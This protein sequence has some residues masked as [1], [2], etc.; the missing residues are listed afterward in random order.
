MHQEY[1][2]TKMLVGAQGGTKAMNSA[3]TF[4]RRW[5]WRPLQV[6]FAVVAIA[7]LAACQHLPLYNKEKDELAK[8]AQK[9]Y[10]DTKVTE[11]LNV[12]EKN[13][14]KLLKAEIDALNESASLRLDI[15]L[16]CMADD[17]PVADG[18]TL[19]AA[20]YVR[21]E[22]EETDLG[23]PEPG[24]VL[25]MLDY[26]IEVA[27]ASVQVATVKGRIRSGSDGSKAIKAL[28]SCGSRIHNYA[29]RGSW[30]RPR[31]CFSQLK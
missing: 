11:A 16:L 12:Q 14:E 21:A 8:S 27:E 22:K 18:S 20:W 2:G 31:Q 23:F 25:A 1:N 19:L 29:A 15:A 24:Q 6:V 5:L 17:R 7:A 26:Q 30:A 3:Q 4:S 13:L 10:T 28:P 9:A